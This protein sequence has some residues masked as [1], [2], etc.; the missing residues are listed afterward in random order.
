[1][2]LSLSK[3]EIKLLLSLMSIAVVV[4]APLTFFSTQ[5]SGLLVN[6]M[7]CMATF[8]S[9][10]VALLALYRNE[11]AIDISSNPNVYVE[12]FCDE[13]NINS[14]NIRVHNDGCSIAKNIKFKITPLNS[15]DENSFTVLMKMGFFNGITTLSS[16]RDRKS[17]WLNAIEYSKKGKELPSY[18]F[19]IEYEN[20]YGEKFVQESVVNLNELKGTSYAKINKT[21]KIECKD[22]IEMNNNILEIQKFEKTFLERSSLLNRN[23]EDENGETS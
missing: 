5:V 12:F 6:F 1:M 15:F 4:F 22:I 2:K 21:I 9:G 10:C 7:I 11:K 18:S 3:K 19:I 23:Q 20:K 8:F 14:V 13:D 16:N 17:F